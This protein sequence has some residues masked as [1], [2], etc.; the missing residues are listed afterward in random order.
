MAAKIT[1]CPFR[2]K[3]KRNWDEMPNVDSSA[4]GSEIR[5]CSACEKKVYQCLNAT[6]L[7]EHRELNHCVMID[8]GVLPHLVGRLA[9]VNVEPKIESLFRMRDN[10]SRKPF[11]QRL[12]PFLRKL[13]SS[14][15]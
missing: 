8:R 14:E 15:S 10:S 4:S 11:F 6:E 5:Y 2:Y 1:N 7:L 9:S 12:S 13:F 3:C